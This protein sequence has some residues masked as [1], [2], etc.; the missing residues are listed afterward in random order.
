MEGKDF[1]EIV[2][3]IVKEDIDG[4]AT[5]VVKDLGKFKDISDKLLVL[6]RSSP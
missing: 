6:A 5:D 2:G 1:R 4:V 3:G